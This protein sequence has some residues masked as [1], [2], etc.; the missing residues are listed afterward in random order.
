MRPADHVLDES[1]NFEESPALLEEFRCPTSA[2]LRH[3]P[4]A[5]LVPVLLPARGLVRTAGTLSL[6]RPDR[7]AILRHRGRLRPLLFSWKRRLADHP[8]D[9]ISRRNQGGVGGP[10]LLPVRL[11]PAG[12]LVELVLTTGTILRL[13]PG[14]DLAWVRSL[15]AT[16]GDTPC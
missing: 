14:C 2:W 10:R 1:D 12:P 8:L 16:L 4:A 7:G 13:V 3:L 15:V 5:P 11:Q 9:T 6:L